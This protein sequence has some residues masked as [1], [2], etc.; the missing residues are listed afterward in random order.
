MQKDILIKCFSF[1]LSACGGDLYGPTGTFTS[2]NYPNPNPRARICEWTITVQEGRRIILTFT[3]LRLSTQQSCNT[4]YLM[5]SVPWRLCVSLSMEFIH[6]D[7]VVRKLSQTITTH[8]TAFHANSEYFRQNE[9]TINFFQRPSSIIA[10]TRVILSKFS[11]Q[12]IIKCDRMCR[13]QQSTQVNF[14]SLSTSGHQ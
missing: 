8:A 13:E 3:N 9:V 2:P 14:T 11:G 12:T 1:C 4:E 10:C 7:V 6:T 5:V